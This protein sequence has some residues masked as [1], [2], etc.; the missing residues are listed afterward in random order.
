MMMNTSIDRPGVERMRR[1]YVLTAG[2]YV[3][4]SLGVVG[5]TEYG[6]IAL[7]NLTKLASSFAKYKIYAITF[8][9]LKIIH[10]QVA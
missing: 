2:A 10:V 3:H 6:V 5:G 9:Y 7:Q 1:K 4:Q 8:L